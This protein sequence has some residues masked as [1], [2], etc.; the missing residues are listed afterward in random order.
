[1]TGVQTC[2]LPISNIVLSSDIG[3]AAGGWDYYPKYN[4]VKNNSVSGTAG[5]TGANND[6]VMVAYDLDNGKLWFGLNGTWFNSGNPATGANANYSNLSGSI[7][8]A[9]GTYSSGAISVNFGQRPFTYTPP[10]GYV[11]LN[12]YN[13]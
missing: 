10:S 12:T 2:A 6:I 1:M 8:P 13:L 9:V 4:E 5:G 11:A 3:N 7:A